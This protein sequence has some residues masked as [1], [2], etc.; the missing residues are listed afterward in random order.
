MQN[1]TI[2]VKTHLTLDIWGWQ[3]HIKILIWLS[4]FVWIETVLHP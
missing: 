1:S 2:Q 4:V 3:A